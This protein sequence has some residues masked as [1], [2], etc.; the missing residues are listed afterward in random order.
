MAE[1]VESCFLGEVPES[2]LIVLSNQTGINGASAILYPGVPKRVYEYAGKNY[3]I[4]PSSIHE[5]LIVPE[6]PHIFPEN[7]REIVRD[8]NKNH[9]AAEEFLSNSIYYFDGNIITKI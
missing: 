3:Y 2:P 5:L 6:D 7:L 4:L 9:I 8:V 1:F